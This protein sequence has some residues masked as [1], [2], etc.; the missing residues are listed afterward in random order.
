MK[1][2]KIVSKSVEEGK[3]E[4]ISQIEENSYINYALDDYDNEIE[5]SKEALEAI[6]L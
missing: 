4:V 3:T 2:E 5:K 6:N 1:F